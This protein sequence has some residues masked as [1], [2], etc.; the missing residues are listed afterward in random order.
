MVVSHR[1]LLACSGVRPPC[2]GIPPVLPPR[3]PPPP[4]P[5]QQLH[6]PAGQQEPLRAQHVHDRPSPGR[7]AL[8]CWAAGW[9]MTC[10]TTPVRKCL[11]W[12]GG[13]CLRLEC[14]PRPPD[15]AAASQA[16]EVGRRRPAGLP[17]TCT[18]CTSAKSTTSPWGGRGCWAGRCADLLGNPVFR[19]SV[20][21]EY[22]QCTCSF[23]KAN[24]HLHDN[25]K[26]PK[27]KHRRHSDAWAG[28]GNHSTKRS[29]VC[30]LL[31][32]A[33]V[34]WTSFHKPQS[35]NNFEVSSP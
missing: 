7:R 12:G 25:P 4:P 30:E 8:F 2:L 22:G 29:K 31:T 23:R 24:K 5:G 9:S 35:L 26:N 13:R 16:A 21:Q 33:V 32:R 17:P 11:K 1:C 6:G 34:V 10:K 18:R 28:M 15:A 20:I 27:D 19:C 3:P 14:N